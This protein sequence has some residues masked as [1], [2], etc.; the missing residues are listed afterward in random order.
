MFIFQELQILPSGMR[1]AVERVSCTGLRGEVVRIVDVSI[2]SDKYE[3]N[4]YRA[5]NTT[6]ESFIARIPCGNIVWAQGTE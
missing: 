4:R 6:N 3:I 5:N 1:R 2:S